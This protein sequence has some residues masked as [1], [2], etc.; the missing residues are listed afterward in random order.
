MVATCGD[1]AD[2]TNAATDNDL[3][4][5]ILELSLVNTEF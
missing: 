2:Q 1:R 4:Q 3:S 5:L